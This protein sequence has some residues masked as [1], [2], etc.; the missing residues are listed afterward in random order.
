M[1][2]K[3]LAIPALVLL[4]GQLSFGQDLYHELAQDTIVTRPAFPG[5]VYLLDGKRLNLQV[6]E[7]FMAGH[8]QAHDQIR[9]AG[10]TS[11]LAAVSFTAG[12]LVFLGGYL[13]SQEDRAAG[14]GLLQ[15]GGAGLGAGFLLT[16]VSSSY[17]HRAVEAYNSDIRQYFQ[18]KKNVQLGLGLSGKGLTLAARFE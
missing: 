8:P 17:K 5:K 7:W 10:V 6:M 18:E 14:Q 9:V 16:L 13:I 4:L 1:R 12:G 3:L 11:Q 15:I 2:K